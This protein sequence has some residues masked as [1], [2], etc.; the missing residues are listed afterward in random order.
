VTTAD[1]AADLLADVSALNYLRATRAGG[2][3]D[4][5]R[6]TGAIQGLVAELI[7]AQNDDGGWPWVTGPPPA[8]GQ[9]QR[10]GPPSDRLTSAAVLWALAEAEHVGLLT[11]TKAADKGV[12]GGEGKAVAIEHP[13]QHDD[14]CDREHLHEYRQHVLRAYQSAVEQCECRN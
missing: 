1:R 3:P 7:A 8:P 11:D 6:L 14:R 5:Q 9:N 12:A 13:D 2:S 4:A 10:T